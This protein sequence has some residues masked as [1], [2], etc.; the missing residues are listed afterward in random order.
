MF[1]TYYTVG[2]VVRLRH[3]IN[4]C[5]CR[6]DEMLNRTFLKA[7]IFKELSERRAR[8]LSSPNLRAIWRQF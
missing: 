1:G 2:I 8:V 4:E 3:A 6:G 5:F 7:A